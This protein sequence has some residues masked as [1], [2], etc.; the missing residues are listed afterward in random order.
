MLIYI[1]RLDS[2]EC[3]IGSFFVTIEKG[4]RCP[5]GGLNEG[6]R[7]GS[8]KPHHVYE[9]EVVGARSGFLVSML[10]IMPTKCEESVQRPLWL[11]ANFVKQG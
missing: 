10:L 4:L 3:G 11:F 8:G 5:H 6:G 7:C 1:Q 2:A 9:E